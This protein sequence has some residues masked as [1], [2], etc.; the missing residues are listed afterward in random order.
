MTDATR[1]RQLRTELRH[2][3]EAHGVAD[4]RAAQMIDRIEMVTRWP[5]GEP[6][7]QAGDHPAQLRSEARDAHIPGCLDDAIRQISRR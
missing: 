3:L 7:E 5:L 2:R 6:V 4:S 1:I